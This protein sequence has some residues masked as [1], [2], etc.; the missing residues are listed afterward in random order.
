MTLAD[1]W[2]KSGQTTDEAEANISRQKAL[3]QQ[4][5]DARRAAGTITDEE[6]AARAAEIFGVSPETSINTQIL[7]EAEEGLEDGL[8]NVLDA[9]GRVVA[10]VT[11]GAGRAGWG[12][13]KNIPWWVWAGL[14]V[15]G[16]FR[17]GGFGWLSRKAKA[18]LA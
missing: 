11:D 9:P 18:K 12:V 1:I 7:G 16:F 2:K 17:I 8:G 10:G 13:V 15:Y 6:Y 5:L 3:A 4:R 14:L